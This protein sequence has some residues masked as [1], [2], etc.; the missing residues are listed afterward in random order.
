MFL[1]WKEI[2]VG[3]PIWGKATVA[4]SIA[5]L[6]ICIL[7]ETQLKNYPD[8]NLYEEIIEDILE[9]EIGLDIDL[10]IASPE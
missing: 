9:S 6:S 7:F 1:V 10:S 4:A 2:W 8:D 3:F 5:L